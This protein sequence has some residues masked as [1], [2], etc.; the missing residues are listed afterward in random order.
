MRPPI[1][2]AKIRGSW[3]LYQAGQILSSKGGT[4]QSKPS[5]AVHKP[6]S[7]LP[8]VRDADF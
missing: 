2:L 5:V 4:I 6:A 8:R 3:V 1:P 7:F